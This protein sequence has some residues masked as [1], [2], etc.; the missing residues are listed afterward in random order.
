MSFPI[1]K[2]HFKITSLFED[3]PKEE[4]E[5]LKA[6]AIRQEEKAGKVIY[7]EGSY[8]SGVYILKKGEIKAL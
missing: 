6:R 2:Y 3:M 4:S 1:N 8:S 7:R 5:F